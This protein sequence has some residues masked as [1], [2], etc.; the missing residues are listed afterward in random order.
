MKRILAAGVALAMGTAVAH[1][2]DFGGASTDP[3]ILSAQPISGHIELYGQ[4]LWTDGDYDYYNPWR[5]FG[6]AARANWWF[7]PNMSAQF[8]VAGQSVVES[9]YGYYG[10]FSMYGAA[11]LSKR[12]D[13]YLIG[14]FGGLAVTPEDDEAYDSSIFLGLEGQ[15]YSGPFTVYGQLG[16]IQQVGG[17]YGP[18]YYTDYTFGLPFGQIEGRYFITPNTKLSANVGFLSGNIWGYYGPQTTVT[19]GLELEHKF[20]TAPFSVFGRYQGYSAGAY[21]PHTG[22]RAMAGVRF[23]WGSATLQDEDRNGA[24]LKVMDDLFPLAQNRYWD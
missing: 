1:A 20:G 16:W 3:S 5:G 19:Y 13:N 6:V 17:Y 14:V 2:S 10:L 12:T 18:S 23:N 8:D 22:Y 15:W 7:S 9:Y 21:D 24:T 4:G 11:H